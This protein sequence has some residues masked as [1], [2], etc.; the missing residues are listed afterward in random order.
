MGREALESQHFPHREKFS[1]EGS[2]RQR[3][4][5]EACFLA[6]TGVGLQRFGIAGVG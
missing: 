6:N 1:I 2:M 3:D 4:A 5:G